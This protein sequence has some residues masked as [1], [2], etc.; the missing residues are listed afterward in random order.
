MHC[1]FCQL[2]KEK[3]RILFEGKHCKVILSNPRLMQ[4]HLLVI[5]IKHVEKLSEL[6]K[7]ELQE[8][9]DTVILFQEKILKNL[10][11][12]CDI[13]HNYRP[14]QQQDKFKV[15]HLHIHLQPRFLEDELYYKSQIFEKQVFQDLTTEEMIK[16]QKI[17]NAQ[18]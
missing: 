9:M 6:T 5:P 8:L 17:I 18:H 7:E 1:P 14:F 3:T 16:I 13:K 4:A 10:A 11:P 15:H 12:G 2:D